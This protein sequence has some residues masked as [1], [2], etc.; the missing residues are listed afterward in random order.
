LSPLSPVFVPGV[1]F[2]DVFWAPG[3][4]NPE[5]V[6]S[7]GYNNMSGRGVTSE[8]VDSAAKP[9]NQDDQD[10]ASDTEDSDSSSRRLSCVIEPRGMM[11]RER[12]ASLPYL[13]TPWQSN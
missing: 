5:S 1:Q 12:R 4:S 6:I 9:K 11:V 13:R 3:N 2:S 10:D 7:P 8:R